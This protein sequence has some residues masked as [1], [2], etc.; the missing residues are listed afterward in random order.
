MRIGRELI[1]PHKTGLLVIVILISFFFT[2]PAFSAA[3]ITVIRSSWD[4]GG[5]D[6]VRKREYRF[7][8]VNNGD[9][10]LHIEGVETSCECLTV[11]PHKK[12]Y[13]PGERGE[14]KVSFN[15][16]GRLG[17]FTS[18]IKLFTNAQK[19]A[20]LL[21][22]SAFVKRTQEKRIKVDLPKP[23]ISVEPKVVNLGTVKQGETVLYKLVVTNSGEGDLL[24]Y[25]FGALNEAGTPLSKKPIAKGKKVELTAF[26]QANEKGRINDILIIRCND[27]EKPVLKIRITGIVE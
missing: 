10:D 5:V 23:E 1:L 4:F 3:K 27:P 25:N 8:F 2:G 19:G 9:M 18:S 6:D 20:V 11:A 15:P 12:S 21:K 24:I 22:I 7:R 26:F 13:K 16:S 14:L 17:I